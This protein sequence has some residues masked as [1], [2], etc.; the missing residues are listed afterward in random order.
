[1]NNQYINR[2][3]GKYPISIATSLAMEGLFGIHDNIPPQSSLPVTNCDAVAVN[4]RTIVRNIL[5]SQCTVTVR[6]N[7]IDGLTL[8]RTHVHGLL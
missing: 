6:A 5:G 7:A 8:F 4:A 2:E 3:Q 1:M